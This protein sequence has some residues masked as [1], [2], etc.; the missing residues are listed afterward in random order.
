[1]PGS[2]R[3]GSPVIKLLKASPLLHC[4]PD[5]ILEQLSTRVRRV[6]YS[7]NEFIFRKNDEGGSLMVIA[8]GR[9]KIVSVSHNGTEVLLNIIERGE[10]FGEIALLD[11]KPRSADAIAATE[12]ELISLHRSDYLPVLYKNPESVSQMTSILCDRVRHTSAFVE[13]TVF[14]DASSRLLQGM[15]DLAEHYGRPEVDRVGIRIEHGLS[16]QE[17][18]ESVGLTRVSINRHLSAWRERGLIQ[19]GR[20]Y[21][22]VRDM[23]KLEAAVSDG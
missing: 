22:V 11:G 20:G 1:V 17:L 10:V 16:Q 8:S 18:G 14:L 15:K 5:A 2:S 3:D 6:R 12:T 13:A 9:V 23:S 21:I 19:D 4:L 7:A